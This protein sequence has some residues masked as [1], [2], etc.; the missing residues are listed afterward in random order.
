MA[1]ELITYCGAILGAVGTTLG[2]LNFLRD[3]AK[4]EVHLQWDMADTHSKEK[5]GV[6]RVTNTG[7]RAIYYSHVALSLPPPCDPP[8]FLIRGG[9]KGQ[10][11]A[12][13]DEPQVCI[14]DQADMEKYKE[15]WRHIRAQVTDSTGKVW[16]SKT[17][18]RRPVPSWAQ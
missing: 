6:I 14:V 9:L 1:S 2:V 5:L 10:K 18:P 12:E 17:L 13:G 16:S 15:H 3:R 4:I 11:I 7:R 8:F